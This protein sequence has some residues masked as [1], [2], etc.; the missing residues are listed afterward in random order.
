MTPGPVPW[1]SLASAKQE[2]PMHFIES[3][4]GSSPDGGSGALE[5]VSLTVAVLISLRLFAVQRRRLKT[6]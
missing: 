1:V 5:I 6:R 3:L 4:F 2:V